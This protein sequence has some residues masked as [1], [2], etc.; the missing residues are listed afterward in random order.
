[1]LILEWTLGPGES[2]E[3]HYVNAIAEERTRR[4]QLYDRLQADFA[5]IQTKGRK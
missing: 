5:A 1:M 4:W 3:V 2:R